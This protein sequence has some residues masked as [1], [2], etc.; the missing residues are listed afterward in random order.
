M[1]MRNYIFTYGFVDKKNVFQPQEN[2]QVL[3][4]KIVS[5]NYGEQALNKLIRET[6]GKGSLEVVDFEELKGGLFL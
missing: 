3:F 5:A 1:M 4:V 6:S 2:G